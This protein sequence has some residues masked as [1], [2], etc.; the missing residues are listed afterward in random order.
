MTSVVSTKKTQ[1][2]LWASLVRIIATLFIFLFHYLKMYKMRTYGMDIMRISLFCFISGYFAWKPGGTNAWQWF[3]HRYKAIMIPYWMVIV[4]VLIA[5]GVRDYKPAPLTD[6]III[7]FG[8]SMFLSNPVYVISWFITFI[9]MIYALVAVSRAINQ[10]FLSGLLFI[11]AGYTF[12]VG[13]SW[14]ITLYL[15]VFTVGYLIRGYQKRKTIQV[16]R[17]RSDT[18]DLWNRRCFIIQSYAY[19]FFL[20]HGVFLVMMIRQF[21]WAAGVTLVGAVSMS[22]LAAWVLK[23]TSDRVLASINKIT[24]PI[25]NSR[26]QDACLTTRN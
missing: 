25:K 14:K 17:K 12:Y 10:P 7:F 22:L 4:P 1:P 5:N 24:I 9:L 19:H 6:A 2:V 26:E 20:V 13:F 3:W 8:G 15:I 23:Q 11:L 18:Y 21:E 16:E